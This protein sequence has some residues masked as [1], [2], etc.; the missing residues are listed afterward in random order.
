MA[1][2]LGSF[3]LI[4]TEWECPFNGT[5]IRIPLR[6]TSQA[7]QSEISKKEASIHDVQC[8][9]E[10]FASDMGSSGLIFLKS[11]KRIVLSI[12]DQRLD[13]VEIV[14]RHDLIG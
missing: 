9:M 8:A 4:N 13:E 10:S 14:N 2:Q 6:T 11:V 3:S 1:N 12:D 5:I 7:E